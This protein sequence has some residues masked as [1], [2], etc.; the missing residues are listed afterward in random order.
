MGAGPAFAAATILPQNGWL[1]NDQY[2]SRL[3]V[4]KVY[5]LAKEGHNGGRPRIQK[6]AGSSPGT[7]VMYHCSD[8]LEQPLVWAIA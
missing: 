2:T 6:P 1:E 3:M 8:M 7:A 4:L 5:L